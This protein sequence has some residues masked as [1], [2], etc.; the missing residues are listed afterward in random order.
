ME[1]P[2]PRR[3]VAD[4]D[5]AD[6][7][8]IGGAEVDRLEG[9]AKLAG[10]AAHVP[11]GSDDADGRGRV[12]LLEG[13]EAAHVLA[14]VAGAGFKENLF[15]RNT[16]SGGKALH[17]AALV[18]VAE[19]RTAARTLHDKEGVRVLFPPAGRLGDARGRPLAQNVAGRIARRN[20]PH[21]RDKNV[22][23]REIRR[24]GPVRREGAAQGVAA[25]GR[26]EGVDEEPEREEEEE[27]KL[28]GDGRWLMADG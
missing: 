28:K 26:G 10:S 27:K 24:D 21:R 15:G 22:V 5:A 12:D 4:A 20:V 7:G 1:V 25:E 6:D 23:G 11:V 13:E 18:V 16:V 3:E 2:F 17:E 9:T 14:G 8:R 19:V